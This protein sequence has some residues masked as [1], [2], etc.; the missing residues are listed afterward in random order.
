M[1]STILLVNVFEENYELLFHIVYA[2]APNVDD[3]MD[4]LQESF[5]R[6][7]LYYNTSIK[8]EEEVLKWLITINKN[9]A[10][11]YKKKNKS[12]E[13]LDDYGNMVGVNDIPLIDFFLL[14]LKSLKTTVPE[15]LFDCLMMNIL[16]GVPLLEV[17]RKSKISYERL[18]YWK[19]I[20]LKELK[21]W[22]KD[23]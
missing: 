9:T 5:L 15:N 11:T 4:I 23:A 20:V 19:I 8:T 12:F 17:S 18:R 10:K 3:T 13:S 14:D 22:I 16:G 1:K 6:A 2:I 21:E 7:F